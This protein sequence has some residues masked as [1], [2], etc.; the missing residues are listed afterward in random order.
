M[1]KANVINTTHFEIR[2]YDLQLGVAYKEDVESVRAVLLEVAEK[3][4]LCLRD[5]KAQ[6]IFMGFGDS[7]VNLQFSVWAKRESFLD[8]R[9]TIAED[10]KR[11]FD[12]AGIEIPFPHRTLYAGSA[13]GPLPVHVITDASRT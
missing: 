6:V 13:T 9:N 4:L 5:P 10:V 7:A 8:L 1:L 2:R 12:K 3:N 11:A